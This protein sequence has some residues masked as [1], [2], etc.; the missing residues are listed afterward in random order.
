MSPLAN[1]IPA[2]LEVFV[3]G[4]CVGKSRTHPY[5]CFRIGSVW[6]MRDAERKNPRDYRKEEYVAFRVPPCEVD[7]AARKHTRG[8]FFICAVY[9]M[10]EPDGP[11]REDYKRL[12][13]RLLASEPL[14]VHD[15]KKIPRVSA[16]AKIVQVR[17]HDLAEKLGKATRSRPILPEHLNKDAPFRQYVALDG[18]KVVGWVRSVYAADS[19]W[20]ADMHVRESHRR[21]GIGK[22][23]LAKMLRDD[24]AHGVK[25][26]VLLSSH[27]GAL[28]YPHVGYRQLGTLLIYAPRKS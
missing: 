21:R 9:A 8:R 5:E 25:K 28:L 26:S 3:R 22:A 7:A 14:F 13:Y 27:A 6:V 24:R 4:F 19:T 11:L 1:E 2:T 20:C 12:G 18:D 17:T 10:N 16:P 15:L 23:L